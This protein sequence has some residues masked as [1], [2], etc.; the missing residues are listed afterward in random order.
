[1]SYWFSY[2]RAHQYEESTPW[3]CMLPLRVALS[4]QPSLTLLLTKLRS[5]SFLPAKFS[6]TIKYYYL[7]F[8]YQTITLLPAVQEI[9]VN[10]FPGWVIIIGIVGGLLLLLLI[11]LILTM[12]CNYWHIALTFIVTFSVWQVWSRSVQSATAKTRP[13]TETGAN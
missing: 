6:A 10:C 3:M 7:S 1:M 11:L 4:I 5:V 13:Q 8:L 9:A 12:V 2:S